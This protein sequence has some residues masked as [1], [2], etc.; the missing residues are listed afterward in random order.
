MM[1]AP[2]CVGGEGVIGVWGFCWEEGSNVEGSNV[3]CALSVC[4]LR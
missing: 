3:V 2:K 4:C 1:L